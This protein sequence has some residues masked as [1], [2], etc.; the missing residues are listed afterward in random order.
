[1]AKSMG[2]ARKRTWDQMHRQLT[3]VVGEAGKQDSLPWE[4]SLNRSGA[5]A[6]RWRSAR[7]GNPARGDGEDAAEMAGTQRRSGMQR[8]S[9]TQRRSRTQQRSGTQR[10]STELTAATKLSGAFS[11]FR[12]A[13]RG[14]KPVSDEARSPSTASPKPVAS[15]RKIRWSRHLMSRSKGP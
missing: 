11:L 8:S 4:V 10:S 2:G 9:G 1:M 3:D 7:A 15:G 12:S 14:G 5:R 13:R 6:W